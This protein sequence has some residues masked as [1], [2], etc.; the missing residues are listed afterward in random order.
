MDAHEVAKL[1]LGLYWIH[2]KSSGTSLAAG[3]QNSAGLRWLASVNWIRIGEMDMERFWDDVDRVEAIDPGALESDAGELSIDAMPDI[4][5]G[6]A[7]L[8]RK[9]STIL[10]A[11]TRS[12]RIDTSLRNK[13][14]GL[15][16]RT[17]DLLKLHE[18]SADPSPS[19]SFPESGAPVS[20][21]PGPGPPS[22]APGPHGFTMVPSPLDKEEEDQHLHRTIEHLSTQI[23]ATIAG[24]TIRGHQSPKIPKV[25]V[26]AQ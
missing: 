3:G 9:L 22:P 14:I 17:D 16:K 8:D 18:K 19:L 5:E 10:D 1:P 12:I 6:L 13:V 4:S 26:D 15:E 20:P 11:I 24:A 7:N 21:R 23:A 2:W 25:V